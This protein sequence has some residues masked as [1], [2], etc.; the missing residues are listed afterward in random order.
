MSKN[1]WGPKTTGSDGVMSEDDFIAFAIAKVGDGGTTWRK[2]V[3]KAYNAITNHDGQAGANDKYPHKGKAVCHVS[4]GKRG[5][6][7]GVS[8]FFTAK[9]EVVASVIGIG[10]HIGSASY[11]LEWRLPSW[12]TANSA[13]ITL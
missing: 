11:H 12:D 8:V 7:N 1:I 5:A 6:G 9:G 4:E 2:N 13:N 3:A 10:Y